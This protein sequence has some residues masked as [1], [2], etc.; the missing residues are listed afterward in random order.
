MPCSYGIC[1]AV[2]PL[3]NRASAVASAGSSFVTSGSPGLSIPG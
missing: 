2:E 1:L 3:R